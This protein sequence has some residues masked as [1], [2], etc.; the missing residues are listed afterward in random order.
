VLDEDTRTAILRLH[1]QGH[2]SRKISR[3]L[4]IAR[5]SVRRIIS[6]GTSTVPPLL[7][8]ERAEP[9]REQIL[10]LYARYEGHLGRV[11]DALTDSGASVS[12][13]ALTAFCRRHGI[14]SAPPPPAGHYLFTPG[15]EM[16]HDTSPHYASIAG[17]RVR[18]QTASV[19]LCFSRMIFFQHYPRFTRFECKAFLAAGIDYFKGSAGR[20]MVDNSNVVVDHPNGCQFIHY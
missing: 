8:A 7:R 11:H 12:Y 20:C 1:V 13:P 17:T 18:I 3:A 5:D 10:E 2:G 9:W 16:Q 19:V 4:G 6:S 15:E 14:G